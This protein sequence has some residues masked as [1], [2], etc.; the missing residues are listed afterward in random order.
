MKMIHKIIIG[1]VVCVIVL[2]FLLNKLFNNLTSEISKEKEKYEKYVGEKHIID[3]DT[4]TITDYSILEETFTLSNGQKV[5]Y[6][7]VSNA[8]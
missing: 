4:L 3:K 6:K 1:M 8:R 5:S 7:L 2:S